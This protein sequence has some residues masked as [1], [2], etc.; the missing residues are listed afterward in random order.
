ML[1][2]LSLHIALGWFFIHFVHQAS[3]QTSQACKVFRKVL[4]SY[5][6]T[7]LLPYL[8]LPCPVC[9]F[10]QVLRH[11]SRSSAERLRREEH[12]A[13]SQQGKQEIEERREER[14][15]FGKQAFLPFEDLIS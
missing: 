1:L 14:R 11:G 3:K 12:S 5:T 4:F 8:L 6:E 7:L 9:F 15:G 2:F 10:G 13:S